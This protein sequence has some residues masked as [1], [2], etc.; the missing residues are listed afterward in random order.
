MSS[1]PPA[2]RLA[3]LVILA[4][5]TFIDARLG[6]L[7][8][9]VVIL[10]V[11]LAIDGLLPRFLKFLAVVQ[12][13]MTVMLVAVWGWVAKAPPG[14]PMGSD[15]AA[16]VR[17]A[18]LISFRLA[19]LGGAFQ[20]VMLS[21]PSR[22][23]PATLRGWGLRGEGLVVALGV[24]AVEP[25]LKLRANRFSLP[26]G[27]ADCSAGAAGRDSNNCPG[28][29]VRCSCGRFVPRFIAPRS[30]NNARCCSAFSGCPMNPSRFHRS[31]A[32]SRWRCRFCGSRS[33]SPF[34]GR[35]CRRFDEPKIHRAS[36][37]G[38]RLQ[39]HPGHRR[40][41]FS[42]RSNLLRH[43]CRVNTDGRMYL[44]PEVYFAL[45]GLTTSV[46]Q[47]LELHAGGGL[48]SCDC[49]EAAEKLNLT[50][51]MEQHPAVLSGGEQTCLAILCAV[52]LKPKILAADCAW[53]NWTAKSLRSRLIF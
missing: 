32:P 7:L 40:A 51:L 27:L 20:L 33:R 48:E 35:D 43:F 1:V 36:S 39:A 26:G 5:A 31:L 18:L 47:E 25:E 15:P 49:M 23:L 9:V 29:S 38:P 46:R 12:L 8:V 11:F 21:I 10:G 16:G 19:V 2:A 4:V 42:G 52:I 3:T 6:P 30:G 53:N 14:M 41:E 22:L 50:K 45:S 34:A 28:F 37:G 24:F 17:F 44:G 13:P